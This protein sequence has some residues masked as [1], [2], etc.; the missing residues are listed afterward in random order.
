MEKVIAIAK[1]IKKGFKP[2]VKMIFYNTFCKGWIELFGSHDSRKMKY[3]ISVCLIFKN[4]APFLKEWLDYHLAIGVDHFYLYNNN[5]DDDFKDVIDSYIN[6]G[7]VT[8]MDWPYQQA[9]FKCYEHCY[10]TYG[11]E[12]NWISFLDA[13]EFICL[14]NEVD[15]NQWI[16]AFD[17]YPA[18]IIPFLMFGTSG[19]IKHDYSRMVIEQYTQCWNHF[20]HLGKC[21]INTRYQISDY[22]LWH[23][24]HHTYMRYTFSFF[25]LTVPAVNQFKKICVVGRTWGKTML[26]PDKATIQINHYYTKALEIYDRKANG[27]DVL[28]AQNLKS[29]YKK[30]YMCENGCV[31]RDYTILRMITKMKI[32]Q[33][34]LKKL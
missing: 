27:S 28:F 33:G 9:Q 30:F 17:K 13:D 3:R 21:L 29:D 7:V 16:S 20:F 25:T 22:S 15:I 10:K 12:S 24:H 11:G 26:D 2:F 8:L 23:L 14:R 4:E 19:E 1:E 32:K 34:I 31:T 6:N 5:S 18:I